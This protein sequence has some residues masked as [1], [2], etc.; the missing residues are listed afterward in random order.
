MAPAAAPDGEAAPAH[1][2]A[3]HY[4]DTRQPDLPIAPIQLPD[5]GKQGPAGTLAPMVDAEDSAV[6]TE[7]GKPAVSDTQIST[8]SQK[9]ASTHGSI[10]AD[11]PIAHAPIPHAESTAGRES[12]VNQGSP[13]R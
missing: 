3:P 4:A 12:A 13:R 8:F 6:P 7:P 5:A 1:P 11:G 9:S 2:V 10:S